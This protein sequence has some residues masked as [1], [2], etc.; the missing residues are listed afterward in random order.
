LF[1]SEVELGLEVGDLVEFLSDAMVKDL[2]GCV[3]VVLELVH[4]GCSDVIVLGDV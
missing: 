3:D 1:V 4:R 2:A